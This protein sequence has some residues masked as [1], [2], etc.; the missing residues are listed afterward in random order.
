MN[1]FPV[2]HTDRL[3]LVEIK[4]KHLKDLFTLFGDEN[5]TRFYNLLILTN[6]LEAQKTIDHFQDRFKNKL[7]IRWGIALKDQENIIGTIGFNNFSKNHKANIGYDLQSDHWNNG[8]VTE[9][10]STIINYG[11]AKL[12]IN[13]IEAEVMQGNILSEKVLE[14]LKFKKEGVL[15]DWK[16]WNEKYYDM[17]MFSLL[18]NERN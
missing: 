17:T 5:V 7:G 3:D 1:S 6:E 9:A 13:R 12:E 14:K 2:L 18:R 4:Q 15:R 11:F 16:F 10:L 8:Y